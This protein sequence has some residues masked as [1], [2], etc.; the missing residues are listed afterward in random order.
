MHR[1]SLGQIRSTVLEESVEEVQAEEVPVDRTKRHRLESKK[2]LDAISPGNNV[3]KY[4]GPYRHG[5]ND[6]D[7]RIASSNDKKDMMNGGNGGQKEYFLKSR[8]NAVKTEFSDYPPKI[9]FFSIVSTIGLVEHKS[10]QPLLLQYHLW[11]NVIHGRKSNR[12]C[13]RLQRQLNIDGIYYDYAG[14]TTIHD[15]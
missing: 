15:L 9:I 3:K 1:N 2:K 11:K 4:D 6:E 5:G 12:M 14:G 10:N 7:G 13:R 8:C